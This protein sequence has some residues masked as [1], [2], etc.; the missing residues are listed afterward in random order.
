MLR[1]KAKAP[2]KGI[3]PTDTLR[4]EI[5][6][7]HIR[8]YHD[9]PFRTKAAC[10]AVAGILEKA[11]EN[12]GLINMAR[13]LELVSGKRA[14]DELERRHRKLIRRTPFWLR[15]DLEAQKD[16]WTISEYTHFSRLAEEEVARLMKDVPGDDA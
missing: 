10:G 5:L 3:T 4:L 9:D 16:K 13:T 6:N 1:S 8:E 2:E 12:S 11:G 7:A 15:R 14:S